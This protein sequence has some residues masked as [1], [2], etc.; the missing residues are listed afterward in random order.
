MDLD[1][2]LEWLL[3][4]PSQL[5]IKVSHNQALIHLKAEHCI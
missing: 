1:T 2:D 4:E 5:Q 3:L